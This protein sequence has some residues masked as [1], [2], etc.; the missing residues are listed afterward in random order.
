MLLARSP[1]QAPACLKRLIHRLASPHDGERVPRGGAA[2]RTQRVLG[3]SDLAQ[4]PVDLLLTAER[5][6]RMTLQVSARTIEHAWTW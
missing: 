6:M 5:A 2:V 1:L 3:V 4:Q